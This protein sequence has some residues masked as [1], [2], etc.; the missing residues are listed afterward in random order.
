[1]R[2]VLDDFGVTT[3]RFAV[4]GR[5]SQSATALETRPFQSHSFHFAFFCFGELGGYYDQAEIDHEKRT[6][7]VKVQK[8]SVG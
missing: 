2:N 7:L 5:R 4:V 3:G 8:M 6:D 1:M